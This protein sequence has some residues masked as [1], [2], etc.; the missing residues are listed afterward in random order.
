MKRRLAFPLLFLLWAWVLPAWAESPL[1]LGVVAVYSK[2]RALQQWR[3]LGAYLEQQLGQRVEVT[4]YTLPE[5]DAAVAKN[6][7]DVVFTNPAHFIPLQQ[8]NSLSA[9]L[10][11]VIT[12]QGANEIK[13]FGGV[14][15]TRADAASINTL[16]D[17]PG[18]R[19]AA[20]SRGAFGA[21]Q[22][23]AFEMLEAGLPVPDDASLVIERAQDLIVA[24][25]VEGRADV[26]FVRTGILESL[27]GDG[28]LDLSRIKIINRQNLASFPYASSTRIYPEWPIGVLPQVSE[29]TARQLTST[30]LMLKADTAAARAAGIHGFSVPAEYRA[31]EEVLRKLHAPPFEK[32]PEFT[33]RDIWK[34]HAI[35]IIAL[36]VLILLL[37]GM[38]VVLFLQNHVILRSQEVFRTLF[39]TVPQGVVYHNPQG[40]VTAA[41]P[42][43]ERILGLSF[44]QMHRFTTWSWESTI[45]SGSNCS[46]STSIAS[47]YSSAAPARWI[48]S[49]PP[50][51][52]SRSGSSPKG[53]SSG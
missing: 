47:R 36:G 8:R 35:W 42:A 22:L 40:L 32:G 34:R 31:V 52:T 37:S 17:I 24:D 30:L 3:P 44:A 1:R 13:G 10:A 2:D 51:R 27:A 9:P 7:V 16:A 49:I 19:I 45:L 23:Q 53:G 18:R 43:A 25:V 28:R 5:F 26:G 11:T 6:Q 39:E 15:F 48:M 21:F 50:W 41:N 29:H 4:A 38:S 12:Q 46:G 20:F 33:W 14:I